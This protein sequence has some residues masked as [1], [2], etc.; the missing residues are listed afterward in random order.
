MVEARILQVQA[1]CVLPGEVLANLVSSLPIGQKIRL[2]I[3]RERAAVH[4]EAVV[5]D[6]A[7]AQAKLKD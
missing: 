6:W 2:Q 7:K 1:E 4:V 3:W 5:G